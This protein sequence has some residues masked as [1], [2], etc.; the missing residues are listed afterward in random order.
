MITEAWNEISADNITHAW[1]KL[2]TEIDE[3]DKEIHDLADMNINY[4]QIP[5]SEVTNWLSDCEEVEE[6]TETREDV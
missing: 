5:I 6:E 4:G 3:G 2:L 1:R